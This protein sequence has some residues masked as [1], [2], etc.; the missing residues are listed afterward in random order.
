MRLEV[1]RALIVKTAVLS[2]VMPCSVVEICRCCEM[3][4]CFYLTT[5]CHIQ[6]GII[7]QNKVVLALG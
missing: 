1:L 2:D 4:V 6:A 5:Q 3:L 7:L